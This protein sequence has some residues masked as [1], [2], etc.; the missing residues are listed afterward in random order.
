VK[1]LF[2]YAQTTRTVTIRVAPSFLADQSNPAAGSFVW[3][4]HV[5]IENDGE[6]EVQL[7]NRHWIITDALGNVQEVNGAGVIGQ[8]PVIAPGESY[9]YVSGCP[10]STPSGLMR[11]SYEM[12]DANGEHFHA[13]IPDFSL[14]SPFARS[15][16]H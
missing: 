7:L 10:L 6:V 12:V 16:L 9:D 15:S 11:G 13:V 2:P 14:D 1:I 8:Q 4:Y 5:R 3:A